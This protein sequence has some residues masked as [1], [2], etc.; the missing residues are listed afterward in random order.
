MD[1]T[2]NNLN[3]VLVDASNTCYINNKKQNLVF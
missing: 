1:W 3:T 2:I